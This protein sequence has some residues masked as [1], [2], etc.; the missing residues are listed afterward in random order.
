MLMSYAI[1]RMDKY[2]SGDVKGIEVHDQRERGKSHTN[3]DI[4]FSKSELNVDLHNSEQINYMSKIRQRIN[5]LELKKAVRKDA[6][7]MLQCLVTSDK[8]FF[9]SM[10]VDEQLQ[11]FRHAY[12][13]IQLRYGYENIVSA[14]V[15]FDERT[16]HM[17]VNFVPVVDSSLCA[18]K[19]YNKQNLLKLHDDFH[20]YVK[21]KGYDLERGESK[22]DKQQHLST[23]EY[24]LKIKHEELKKMNDTI[25]KKEHA[26]KKHLNALEGV[27]VSF[28]KLDTIETKKSLTGAKT[29]LKTEDYDTLCKM[30]HKS[31]FLQEQVGKLEKLKVELDRMKNKNQMG[32]SE[33]MQYIK[34]IKCLEGTIKHREK[35]I[36]V[37]N[38]YIFGKGFTEEFNEFLNFYLQ[39]EEKQIARGQQR[40]TMKNQDD[41]DIEL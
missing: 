36:A 5:E 22:S 8:E 21:N 38:G 19:I 15:H 2:K 31:I 34:K 7:Y 33:R 18:K 27:S 16:P 26:L 3:P 13:F 39:Q 20:K 40:P 14:V 12:N 35:F 11:F 4:D 29:T 17:H 28:G 30:A 6:I 37:A 24:K 32:I 1:I 10:S 23:E 9:D 25:D 41:Y